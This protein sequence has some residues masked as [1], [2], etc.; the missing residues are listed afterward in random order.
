MRVVSKLIGV[1][2]FVLVLLTANVARSQGSATVTLSVKSTDS[3]AVTSAGSRTMGRF[4]K[5]AAP[6]KK[7]GPGAPIPAVPPPG[8]YPDDVTN[9]GNQPTVVQGKH[10]PIYLNMNPS[11]WGDPG[12][13]LTDLGKSDFIHVVD[14]Y[15]GSS[16]NNR[17]TLGTSFTATITVP[18]HPLLDSDLYGL[19]HGAAKLSGSGLDHIYHVFLPKGVDECLDAATCYSPD[20]AST[21]LFCAY[22]GYVTF[23]DKVGT[24]LY[25]VEPYQDVPG[26]QARPGTP[27]GQVADSTDDTL[28]HEVFETISDPGLD[29]W[30]V[31]N[32]TFSYG[33]EIGDL[34]T[35]A[36]LFPGNQI[37]SFYGIV[38]LNDHPY[39]IQPEYS[40]QF[41]GCSYVPAGLGE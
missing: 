2:P 12:G 29:A 16:A 24:V 23:A 11:H 4:D 32:F 6:V 41:H 35:R 26:C 22:H 27:N 36:A 38:N 3:V 14:Q 25:T 18:P 33:N 9:P 40:N 31:Q 20:N 39:S 28:S 10:H 34:C 30:Y 17:Y 1:A 7:F 37:Y 8:F 15:V 5:P 19:L 13:F 21:F